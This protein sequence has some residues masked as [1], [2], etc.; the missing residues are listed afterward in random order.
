MEE[1]SKKNGEVL[2]HSQIGLTPILHFTL[3]YDL[4]LYWA[5]MQKELLPEVKPNDGFFTPDYGEAEYVTWEIENTYKQNIY[6]LHGA[7]HLFDAGSELQKYTWI[8]TGIKLTEQINS[9]LIEEKYP[10]FVAEGTSDEKLNRIKHHAYLA[11][12]YESFSKI[13]GALFI[14]GHS[15][16]E[17]DEHFLKLI[18]KGKV[19]QLYVGIYGDQNSVVNKKIIARAKKMR[20]YRINLAIR[21]P[22]TP[23]LDIYF[24]ESVSAKPWG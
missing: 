2:I 7:L 6:Y 24:Y 10:M 11:K 9:A 22:R 12:A 18:E 4:M 3:N 15:L 1:G 19:K 23:D 17:N 13:A 5:V 16:S 21:K 20:E 14:Y 8:N